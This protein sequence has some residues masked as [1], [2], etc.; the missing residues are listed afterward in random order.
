MARPAKRP[1]EAWRGAIIQAAKGLFLSKG[2]Q[3]TSVADIMEA[4][5]GA[6]GLFYHFFR[7]KEEVMETLCQQLFLE[8][9]PFEKVQDREDL[10]AL[11][12]LRA[13]VAEDRADPDQLELRL[14]AASMLRD[15]CI[16][17]AAVEGNLRV[18]SPLWLRLLEEGQRDGSI[19]TQYAKELS[20]LLPLIDFWLTPSVFP[21]TLEEL[22][23]RCR[24]VQMVLAAAGLPLLEGE[25]LAQTQDIIRNLAGR[26]EESR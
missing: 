7:S 23:H 3:D 6:K 12:K 14:Q 19:P 25:Q 10:T 9:D 1:P 22:L 15:P 11:E 26:E 4:A 17:A 20:Q 8:K 18:L 21:G 5:G 2:F 13:V 24:F 16:L